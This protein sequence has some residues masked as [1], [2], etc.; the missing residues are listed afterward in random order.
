MNTTH[1]TKPAIA[2]NKILV[3]DDEPFNV[4]YL[5]QEL[6]EMDYEIITARNGLEAL[7]KVRAESPDL[8]LLDIMMP[9]MDGFTVL[10]RMKT[11]SDPVIRD[12]PVIIISAMIDLKSVVR[13]IEKGAEDYLPKPFEPVLLRA[14]ISSCLERKHL[15]DEHRGL[16]RTFADKDVADHLMREGFSLGGKHTVITSMFCDIRNF[17]TITEANDPVDVIELINRYYEIVIETVQTHGGNVNQMQG[18]GL[19]S[20][21][22][23]PVFYPDHAQRAVNSALEIYQKLD[24]Y[25]NA[26]SMKGGQKIEIGIGIATGRVVAGYAGVKSRATYLCVGDIVNL[27]ARLESHTKSAK[28]RILIDGATYESLNQ[29]IKVEPLGEELFK[30]KTLPVSIFSV[31]G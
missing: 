14:R 28:K 27:S 25:N 30:G 9:I 20:F 3:V 24:V 19:M 2:G 31:D 22:G 6:E 7:E 12:I 8:V 18:D 15:R 23:A 17:T 1:Q 26:Q 11:D 16:I 4:D 10:D 29:S 5:Q 21:F 13:G